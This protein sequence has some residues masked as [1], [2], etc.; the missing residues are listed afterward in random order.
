MLWLVQKS[1]VLLHL[2]EFEQVIVD[3][4]GIGR[5]TISFVALLSHSQTAVAYKICIKS[6]NNYWNDRSNVWN[7][8]NFNYNG[9]NLC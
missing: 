6:N 7:Y 9:L 2:A 1:I 8:D 5:G 4:K 3:W